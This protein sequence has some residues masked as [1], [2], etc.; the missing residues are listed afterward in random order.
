HDDPGQ[1]ALAGPVGTHDR[2]ALAGPHGQVDSVQDLL[3]GDRCGQ[4][5]DL[6]RA[7]DASPS[8]SSARVVV[9]TTRPST[10]AASHTGTGWLAGPHGQVDSVQDLLAGDRCGQPAD[11]ERAHDASPS[12]SS[13]RV[14]VTT[15]RPSTTEASNTGT[16]WVA[17]RVDGTPVSRSNVLPCFGHSS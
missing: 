5:A 16:G 11:L 10:T 4:P 1:G 7:H 6:E 14:I 13:A 2:V 15:T 12:A 8:A 3:A 17:G 9:T